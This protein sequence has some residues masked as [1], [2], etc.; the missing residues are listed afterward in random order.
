MRTASMLSSGDAVLAGSDSDRDPDLPTGRKTAQAGQSTTVIASP[1][2]S[3]AAGVATPQRVP[4]LD[5]SVQDKS[6]RDA[7]LAAIETVLRHGRLIL[8]PEVQDLERRSR[9]KLWAALWHRRGVRH[10]RLDP[11][12][13]GARHR[14][15]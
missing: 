9:R 13:E 10:G 6:E 2:G 15:G 8:G 11:G 7:I 14:G 1:T 12:I 3:Y 5:L 4:F